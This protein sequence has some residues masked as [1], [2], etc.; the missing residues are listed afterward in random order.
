MRDFRSELIKGI[1]PSG[2][3]A[4]FELVIGMDD[5]ISLGVGEPDFVTPWHICEAAI[6]SIEKGATSYTSNLGLL[7]LRERIA[8]YIYQSSCVSYD[9]KSEIIIT[10]GAS[11]AMDLVFRAILNPGDEVIIL[12]P[13]YVA[14]APLVTLAGG[15]PVIISMVCGEKIVLDVEKIRNKITSRTKA[16]FINYPNN[17]T[18]KSFVKEELMQI[19]KL[20]AEFDLLVVSDE[21]YGELTYDYDHVSFP[22]LPDMKK[23][24]VLL[25]GFS[26]AFA[27]TGWRIG[28]AA[29]PSDVIEAM[30]KIHQYSMLCAPIA[31]QYAAVEALKRGNRDV[32]YMKNEYNRRRHM[33]VEGFNE[34]GLACQMPEGAFYAFPSIKRLPFTSE[35]FCRKLL[36]EETVAV[37]PGT[38]FGA[39]GEGYIRCAYA[40]SLDDIKEALARIKNFLERHNLDI[41]QKT[42]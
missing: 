13:S 27:M 2:I 16:I 1:P 3:R 29:G 17:P 24:T 14:Y 19:A 33:I 37:V 11:E 40:A 31:G 26:K 32:N 8:D 9:P 5:V 4:F 12:E 21:I 23:R 25:S 36:Q 35:Q 10:V 22:T 39:S 30:M 6:Y 20:S 28:Y 7:E 42:G 15:V 18:G 41:K 34:L 38:A